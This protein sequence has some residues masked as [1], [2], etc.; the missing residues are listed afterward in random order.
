MLRR[1][2]RNKQQE[3]AKYCLEMEK[4][5]EDLE[6]IRNGVY[7]IKLPPYEIIII[8]NSNE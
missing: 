2:V 7:R 3:L 4:Q 8:D 6:L 1:V 5:I